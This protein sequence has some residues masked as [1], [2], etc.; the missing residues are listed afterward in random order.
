MKN[1][2]IEKMS[3]DIERVT[4][5]FAINLLEKAPVESAM[6]VMRRRIKAIETDE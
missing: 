4:L 3:E 5:E 6:R 1:D 2:S